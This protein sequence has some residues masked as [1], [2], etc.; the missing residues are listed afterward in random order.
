MFRKKQSLAL[1]VWHWTNS[2]VIFLLLLTVVLRKTFLSVQ[3]NKSLILNQGVDLGF[4]LSDSQAISLAKAIRNQMW[5]WHPII[6][7]VAIGLLLF[8]FLLFFNSRNNVIES[9]DKP[10]IYKIIKKVHSL[11]YLL[12]LVMGITGG[13]MYWEDSLKLSNGLSH[14]I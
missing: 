8:R 9:S 14:N 7:F 13:I 5:H 4:V 11:F 12:L 3:M 10:L 1:R 2:G 6:G